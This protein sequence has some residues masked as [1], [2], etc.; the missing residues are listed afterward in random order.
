MI[1]PV[2]QHQVKIAKDTL[3]M[4]DVGVMVM[5]GMSKA[6]AREILR[7]EG[8]RKHVPQAGRWTMTKQTMYVCNQCGKKDTIMPILNVHMKIPSFIS[9]QLDFCCK[10]CFF[11][12]FKE[13]LSDVN[14]G[15]ELGRQVS[16]WLSWKV[17]VLVI[18]SGTG[19]TILWPGWMSIE[20]IMKNIMMKKN[21][22]FVNM[23]LNQE[24]GADEPWITNAHNHGWAW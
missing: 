2:W 17:V 15:K 24:V 23:N 4:N 3:K 21:V 18:W 13:K 19:I 20:I 6:E 12:Y 7:I 16:E 5:G 9:P 11:K 14:F 1:D 22:N 10:E 8:Q